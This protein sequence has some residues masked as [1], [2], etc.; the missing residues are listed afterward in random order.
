VYYILGWNQK[1]PF[2]AYWSP[3]GVEL[4]SGGGGYMSRQNSGK[5]IVIIDK[6]S[7]T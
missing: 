2:V 5:V 4:R 3:L 6:K 7:S 1:K